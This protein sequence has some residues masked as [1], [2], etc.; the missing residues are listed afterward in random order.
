MDPPFFEETDFKLLA[1]LFNS[2]FLW[3]MVMVI[4]CQAKYDV[5]VACFRFEIFLRAAIL[6]FMT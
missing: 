2:K 4:Q 1:I 6:D 3:R 5:V